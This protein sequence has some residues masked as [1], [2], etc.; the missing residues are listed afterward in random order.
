MDNETK[1]VHLKR[2]DGKIVQGCDIY[3]GRAINMGGWHLKKSKWANPYKVKD[4]GLEGCL[5]LY[6]EYVLSKPQLMESLEE[7]RN[8]ELGCWCAPDRCHG[9]ILIELLNRKK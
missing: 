6:K 1:V 4:Y 5:R 7:L 8:R 9:D 2:K 3:I